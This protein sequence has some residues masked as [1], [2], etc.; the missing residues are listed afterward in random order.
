[1]AAEYDTHP[2]DFHIYTLDEYIEL[3]IDYIERLRPDIVLERFVSQSPPELLHLTGWKIKNHE[4][5]ERLKHRMRERH[6]W[7]GRLYRKQST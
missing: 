4:Y 1:M 6:T 3:V 7:Q 2:H 5:T